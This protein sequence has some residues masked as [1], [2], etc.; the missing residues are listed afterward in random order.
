MPKVARRPAKTT[1]FGN[2]MWDAMERRA[3]ELG[4]PYSYA[5]LSTDILAYTGNNRPHTYLRNVATAYRVTPHPEAV[6]DIA[7]A[8]KVDLDLAL[9]A[10]GYA[11]TTLQDAALE[12]ARGDE[13]ARATI[14]Q[15]RGELA[16]FERS[17]RRAGKVV[18]DAIRR[19]R[20]GPAPR[21][22]SPDPPPD[23]AKAGDHSS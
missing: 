9:L 11:P 21:N 6:R 23:G 20:P 17:M 4:T 1:P 22:A 12:A 5:D 15:V 14:R 10:A 16:S 3:A 2:L 18:G 8:L 13:T 7:I 19:T